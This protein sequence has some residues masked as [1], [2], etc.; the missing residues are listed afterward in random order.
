MP[1]ERPAASA[2][3]AKVLA[4]HLGPLRDWPDFCLP[5]DS[6]WPGHLP[7]QEAR[8]AD[9]PKRAMS[10]PISATMHSAARRSTP[11]MVP[12]SSTSGTKGVISRSTSADSASIVSSKKSS[13]ARILADDKAV[14]G[15]REPS[16]E[17]L[18]AGW[19]PW[20][21]AQGRASSERTSGSW[22]ARHEGLDACRRPICPG[23]SVATEDSLMP[24]SWRTLSRRCASLAPLVYLDF[25]VAGE[26]S[27]FPFIGLGGTNEGR[28]RPWPTSWAD[29]LG[30][31]DICLAPR[32]VAACA[33]R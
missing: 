32:D 30:V 33:G 5:A 23:R 9:G 22:G 14:V 16:V 13:F 8:R 27:Q 29:P 3:W 2:H 11:V 15:G 12:S 1:L 10:V 19:G 20:R 25:A 17:S 21:P 6:W 18:G 28:T 24:A 31:G 4:S 7:A 26:V